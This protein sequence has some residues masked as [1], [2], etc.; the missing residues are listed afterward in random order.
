MDVTFSLVTPTSVL[1][2]RGLTFAPHRHHAG[3]RRRR[4]AVRD[5]GRYRAYPG[6]S[7]NDNGLK[8]S[9]RDTLMQ[10]S[11]INPHDAQRVGGSARL[12]ERLS[13]TQ[14][15]S[16]KRR[17]LPRREKSE[18]SFR[19]KEK[20]SKISEDQGFKKLTDAKVE[21]NK[22]N[23]LRKD[24]YSRKREDPR[25]QTSRKRLFKEP[26]I[27]ESRVNI[28]VVFELAHNHGLQIRSQKG[29]NYRRGKSR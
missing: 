6:Q 15:S 7:N 11:A 27:Q 5:V 9:T 10:I 28:D 16:G 20:N 23:R 13:Q 2:K 26:W 1:F 4:D 14:E 19:S 12:L 25:L 29:I 22:R 3:T 18:K 21:R 8:T 17:S 24:S